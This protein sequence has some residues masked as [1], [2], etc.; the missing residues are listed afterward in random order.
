V[1]EVE[2]GGVIGDVIQ[3]SVGEPDSQGYPGCQIPDGG[4]REIE[5][6]FLQVRKRRH[7]KEGEPQ[8]E[9]KVFYL[10]IIYF[11]GTH[12]IIK[13]LTMNTTKEKS[14]RMEYNGET[15]QDIHY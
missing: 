7:S 4:G 5:G 12:C 13:C 15:G 14:L 10:F 6:E 11:F 9:G 2:P 1:V 3:D 8:P